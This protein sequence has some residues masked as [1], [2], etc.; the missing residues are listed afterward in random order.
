M[1]W[2]RRK[3]LRGM[4]VAAGIRHCMSPAGWAGCAS[5]AESRRLAAAL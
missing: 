5:A 2:E 1:W 3:S 4:T